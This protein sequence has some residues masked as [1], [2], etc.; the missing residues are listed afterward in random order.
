M[1]HMR[2]KVISQV[3]VLKAQMT[4]DLSKSGVVTAEIT[5][6]LGTNSFG[7]VSQES[8]LPKQLLH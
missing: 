4:P 5:F 8:S 3:K 1:S 2:Q 7:N 6:T